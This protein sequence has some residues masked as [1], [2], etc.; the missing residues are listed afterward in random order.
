MAALEQ[1]LGP[2]PVQK[3]AAV[4]AALPKPEVA[5]AVKPAVPAA[6]RVQ[7]AAV[8]KP[9]VTVHHVKE[10][11]TPLAKLNHGKMFMGEMFSDVQAKTGTTMAKATKPAGDDKMIKMVAIKKDSQSLAQFAAK[12]DAKELPAVIRKAD[13]NILSNPF[14][15]KAVAGSKSSG[16]LWS[17]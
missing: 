4:T 5:A 16:T 12:K 17:N 3:A 15:D 7:K 10:A 2:A 13:G 9:A 14:V 8:V 11:V 1:A 6:K